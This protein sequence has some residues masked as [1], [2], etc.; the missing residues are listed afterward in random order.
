LSKFGIDSEKGKKIMSFETLLKDRDIKESTYI[1]NAETWSLK[2]KNLE[3]NIAKL[4]E[5]LKINHAQLE[6]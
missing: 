2:G 3:A 4:R 1:K 5:W 6:S